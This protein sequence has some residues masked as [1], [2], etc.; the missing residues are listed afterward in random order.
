MDIVEFLET[1]CGCKLLECQKAFVRDVYK[2][3]KEHG[4][5]RIVMRKDKNMRNFHTYLKQNNLPIAKE[6]LSNGTTIDCNK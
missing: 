3:Y 2:V 6:L 4:D 1:Q 5:I